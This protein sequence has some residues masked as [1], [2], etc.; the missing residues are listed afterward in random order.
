[1]FN[2]IFSKKESDLDG[3]AFKRM[4]ETTNNAELVDV[5]TAGEFASGTIK[6]ARNMDI[7]SADFQ[8]QVKKL[9]SEKT[10]FLF[11]RSGGRSGSAVSM[12]EKLG[13]KVYN[14]TGG[15]GAWPA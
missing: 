1:M 9:D 13:L 8:N 11:C 15:I 7:M 14:L 12:F 6:G 3:K 5:R 10:Y 2:S 4:F